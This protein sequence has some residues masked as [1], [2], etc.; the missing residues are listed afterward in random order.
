VIAAQIVA[1]EADYVLA[2]KDNQPKQLEAIEEYLGRAISARPA[3]MA[4]TSNIKNSNREG[5]YQRAGGSA[6]STVES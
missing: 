6:T 3:R 2:V 4:Y 1:G 5:L